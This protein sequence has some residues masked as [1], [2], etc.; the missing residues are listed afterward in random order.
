M[1]RRNPRDRVRVFLVWSAVRSK[2]KPVPK[3]TYDRVRDPRVTQFWDPD[4]DLSKRIVRDVMRNPGAYSLDDKIEKK[5]IVWD[6]AA[7]YPAGVRWEEAFPPPAYY[8][9]PVAA[10]IREVEGRVS[11]GS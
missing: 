11:G 10:V 6:F 5:T 4:L 9:R 2:D 8:G 3:G 7:V 1:L